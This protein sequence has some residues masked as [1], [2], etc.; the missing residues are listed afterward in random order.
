LAVARIELEVEHWGVVDQ[1]D[2]LLLESLSPK[3]LNSE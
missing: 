1:G 3:M 2:G